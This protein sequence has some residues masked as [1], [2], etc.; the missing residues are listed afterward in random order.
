MTTFPVVAPAGTCA[1]TPVAPQTNGVADV[2][3]KVTV[4]DPCDVPRFFPAI[5]RMAPIGPEVGFTLVIVGGGPV[6]TVKPAPLLA[7]PPTV[8]MTF[9][10]VA[11]LGTV[12]AMLV[13]PQ[14]FA[15]VVAIVPL[16]VTV[17]IPCVWPK[18]VPP[19]VTVVPAGPDVGVR[20]VIVGGEPMVSVTVVTAGEP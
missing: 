19:I 10:V 20:V 16:K 8:T 12:T 7:T 17:P 6:T 1:T 18:L 11:A 4:L 2:P 13:G 5:V 9:P 15:F 3:L 14:P